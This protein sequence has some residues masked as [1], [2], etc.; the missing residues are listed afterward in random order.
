M[1]ILRDL[2]ASNRLIALNSYRCPTNRQPLQKPLASSFPYQF[3]NYNIIIIRIPSLDVPLSHH[4]KDMSS[5]NISAWLET[6]PLF[7]P[8]Q[9]DRDTSKPKA[10]RIKT[11]HQSSIGRLPTP[12]PHDMGA[13]TKR[14]RE[15]EI[16]E[17]QFDQSTSDG[18]NFPSPPLIDETT[19]RA[20]RQYGRLFQDLDNDTSSASQASSPKSQASSRSKASSPSKRQRHAA[21]EDETGHDIFS[22]AQHDNWQPDILKTL[23]S[24][25]HRIQ[26]GNRIAPIELKDQV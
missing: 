26:R 11:S 9:H 6:L 20:P 7:P 21:L 5:C 24:D 17:D 23:K 1:N 3:N 18:S 25:L 22:F 14:H 13:S 16:E 19:P 10:K 15:E 2:H 4:H 8:A 12:P